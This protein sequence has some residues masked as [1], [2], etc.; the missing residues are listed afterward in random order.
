[1]VCLPLFGGLTLYG[2]LR[3]GGGGGWGA[4]WEGPKF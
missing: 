1:M 3:W 2:P 4:Y